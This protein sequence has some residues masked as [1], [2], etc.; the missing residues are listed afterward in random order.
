[1][2]P[3]QAGITGVARG[4]PEIGQ[5]DRTPEVERRYSYSKYVGIIMDEVC[6]GQ[7]ETF[8]TVGVCGTRRGGVLSPEQIWNGVGHTPPPT[9]KNKV[10]IRMAMSIKKVQLWM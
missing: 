2:H 9:A 10:W 4:D 3:G 8:A 5:F 7:R 6:G 1:M